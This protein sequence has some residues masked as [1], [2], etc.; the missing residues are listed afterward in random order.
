MQVRLRCSKD[1]SKQRHSDVSAS[2][3]HLAFNSPAAST[4][5][6]HVPRAK[7]GK[8]A[9]TKPH[10]RT[11]G[12]K[13]IIHTDPSGLDRPRNGGLTLAIQF[14]RQ[15]VTHYIVPPGATPTTRRPATAS[16]FLLYGIDGDKSQSHHAELRC[17]RFRGPVTPASRPPIKTFDGRV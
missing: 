8:S 3:S 12:S 10:T 7:K 5:V 14:W 15:S 1:V 11:H 6:E 16:G 2:F 13:Y 4:K 17:C 9:V